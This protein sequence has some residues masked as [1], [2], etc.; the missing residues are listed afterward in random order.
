[1]AEIMRKHACWTYVKPAKDDLDDR[2]VYK[3]LY[4]HF[5]GPNSINVMAAKAERTLQA[6]VYN[7]KKSCWDFEKFV[8]LHLQ[9][10]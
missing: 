9:Q 6:M 5:L 2:A 3:A 10:H 8:N 4:D 1:M 7:G